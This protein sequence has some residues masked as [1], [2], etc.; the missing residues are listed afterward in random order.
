MNIMSQMKGKKMFII[1]SR[2]V[3][4]VIFSIILIPPTSKVG[5]IIYDFVKSN[6]ELPKTLFK[7]SVFPY[8]DS[9]IIHA[10]DLK[11]QIT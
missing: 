5:L 6:M 8:H 7:K 9:T 1:F 11:G 4:I 10:V 2:L 3:T